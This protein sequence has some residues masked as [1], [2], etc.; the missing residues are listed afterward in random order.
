M[1]RNTKQSQQGKLKHEAM[2]GADWSWR[3]SRNT[4]N[5]KYG[6]TDNFAIIANKAKHKAMKETHRG[7]RMWRI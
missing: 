1:S 2:K 7:W 4:R 5:N 3:M 6:E